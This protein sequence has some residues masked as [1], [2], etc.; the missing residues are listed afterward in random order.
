MM[1]DCRAAAMTRT[2]DPYQDEDGKGGNEQQA[3]GYAHTFQQVFRVFLSTGSLNL[4][5]PGSLPCGWL[6]GQG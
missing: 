6:G 1:Q 5:V 4:A 2:H 3:D